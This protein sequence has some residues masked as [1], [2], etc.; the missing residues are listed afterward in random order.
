MN[1]KSLKSL[2]NALWRKRGFLEKRY[3]SEAT[4]RRYSFH[5]HQK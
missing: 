3:E 1:I 4:V 5:G 2:K